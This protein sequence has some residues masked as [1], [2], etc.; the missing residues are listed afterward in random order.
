M[1]KKYSR[2]SARLRLRAW[3]PLALLVGLLLGIGACVPSKVQVETFPEL[4]QHRLQTVVVLPFEAL[5][6]P[7]T[8]ISQGPRPSMPTPEGTR[9]SNIS[10]AIPPDSERLD[11]PPEAVPPQAAETVTQ[12]F[13][14]MLQAREDLRI[15]APEETQAALEHF[16]G[17][18][19]KPISKEVARQVA[20]RLKA[21]AALVGQVSIYRER[22]G[23]KL[24]AIPAVVGFEVRLIG[25]DGSVLWEGNYYER[26][27][28]MGEDFWEFLRRKGMFL[29][30][31]QLAA[32]GAEHL[33]E[34]FPSGTA[35][36][37]EK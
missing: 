14:H 28:P 35:A 24:G 19:G 11:Q 26:Q 31:E 23:S 25:D 30:A 6:T 9:L 15:I 33:V 20:K 27:L 8:V 12:L 5:A 32:Y 36:K 21:D 1:R 22:E 4:G 7:Q 10:V 17:G 13:S 18:Q 2:R 34:K 29:T 37:A 3:W 16:G